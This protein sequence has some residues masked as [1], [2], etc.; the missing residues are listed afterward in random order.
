[1]SVEEQ[2][3]DHSSL[4]IPKTEV[5]REKQ[6]ETCPYETGDANTSFHQQEEEEVAAGNAVETTTENQN[7]V[8]KPMNEIR[9]WFE[10]LTMEQK[11]MALGFADSAFL[12][13]LVAMAPWSATSGQG[14]AHVGKYRFEF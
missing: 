9:R 3:G 13:A 10:Q 7:A 2:T 6:E 12:A 1:M 5:S 4:V 14:E 8:E 11:I